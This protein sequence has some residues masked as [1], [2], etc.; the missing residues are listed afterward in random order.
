MS[1]FFKFCSGDGAA[2]ILGT[3]SIFVTSPLD[4]NDPFE[5]RPAWTDDHVKRAK[6]DE[7]LRSQLTGFPSLSSHPDTSVETHRGLADMNNAL[8]FRELH[9]RFRVLSLVR[10]LFDFSDQSKESDE[11]SGLMWSHYADQYQGVCLALQSDHFDNGIRSG[12]FEVNYPP[13]RQSLPPESY[14]V[15]HTLVQGPA[16]HQLDTASGLFLSSADREAAER[17]RFIKILTHKSPAWAYERETRMIYS[18][19]SLCASDQY[20]KI[21]LACPKCAETQVPPANC[22]RATFRDAIFLK[23]EAIRAV[24]FGTDCEMHMVQKILAELADNKYAHVEIYW[25]ALHSSK[26][27]VQYVKSSRVP[28]ENRHYVD[29]IQEEATRRIAEAKGHIYH[30]GQKLILRPSRKGINYLPVK[31]GNDPG[32]RC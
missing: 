6:Q 2:A 4:L 10:G 19:R 32:S 25:S 22:N 24:I 8:I 17:E 29:F 11:Q 28:P 9:R 18:Y 21:E 14:D 3:N 7:E 13:E 5:M 26:Y 1:I 12:G 16:G 23:P 27:R 31:K 30:D 15:W 20:R